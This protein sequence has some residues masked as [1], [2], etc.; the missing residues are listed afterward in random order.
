[1]TCR[2]GHGQNTTHADGSGP[3]IGWVKRTDGWRQCGCRGFVAK[4][5]K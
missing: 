2:C 3:C 5:E 4:G 1:M